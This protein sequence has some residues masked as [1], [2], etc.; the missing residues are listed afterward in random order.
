MRCDDDDYDDDDDNDD[1]NDDS[2]GGVVVVVW[3]YRNSVKHTS[4][5]LKFSFN[6]N[7]NSISAYC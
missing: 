5:C 2:G 7:L 6:G 4:S 1:D 3:E